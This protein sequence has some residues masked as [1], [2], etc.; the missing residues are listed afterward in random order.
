MFKSEKEF[1]D[2]YDS[3]N[4]DKLSMTVYLIKKKQMLEVMII[5]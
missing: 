5:K 4:F 2:N 1:L 3:N